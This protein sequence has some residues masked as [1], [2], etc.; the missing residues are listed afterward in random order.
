MYDKLTSL[1][2]MKG[3]NKIIDQIVHV[4]IA[5]HII[6]KEEYE[7]YVYG[8]EIILSNLCIIGMM[9]AVSISMH[10]LKDTILFIFIFK[11]LREFTGG[12]HTNTRFKCF[13]LTNILHSIVLVISGLEVSIY[14]NQI[15]IK[16]L[17]FFIIVIFFMAPVQSKQNPKSIDELKRN[18]LISCILSISLVLVVLLG[19]YVLAIPREI[20]LV[21]VTSMLIVGVLIIMSYI[22]KMGEEEY[23]KTNISISRKSD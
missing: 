1:K 15:I 10:K 19:L 11:L 8:L 14:T 12:Y 5:N 2:E 20:L 13:C 17:I 7:V 9:L 21:I 3:I 16:S 18:K 23:E 22:K 4:L 6:A